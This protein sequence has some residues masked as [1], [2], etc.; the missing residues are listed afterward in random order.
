MIFL[1]LDNIAASILKGI[2]VYIK[3]V[4]SKLNFTAGKVDLYSD[5]DGTYCPARHSSL[6]DPAANKFMSEYCARMDSFFKSTNGD[7]HFN[8]TTGRTFGEY[9]AVSWLL[10]IRNFRLP[11]PETVITKDG[12]DRLLKNGSDMEFYEGGKFP[13]SYNTTSKEKEN[14]IKKMSNWDGEAI[15]KELR[16]LADKYKI[17]FVEADSQNSVSDYGN[18]SLYSSGKLDP[19][20][21]KK[22][23]GENGRILHHESPI[24][25]Y[26]L[27]SRN[28]GRLKFYLLFPPDYGFCPVRNGIYD[29]L[30]NDFKNYMM[31]NNISYNMVWEPAT[32]SNM[33]RISC[34]I[35]PKFENGALTKLYDTK[36]AVK[37]AAKN[38]DI[39]ITAGDG[40]NDFDMLNPIKYLDE[41]FLNQCEQKSKY[42]DFYHQDMKKCLEDLQKVYNN[43]ESIYIKGLRKELT[44]NGFL[45]TIEKMPIYSIVIKKKNTKLQPLIDAFEN[46]GKIVAVEKGKLDDGIKKIVKNHAEKISK[47]KNSMSE[48]FKSFI[49]GAKK[50]VKNNYLSL[51]IAALIFFVS[52][53]GYAG[54]KYFMKWHKNEDSTG[55]SKF[56]LNR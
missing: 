19:D 49:F 51:K 48:E 52:I 44:E 4:S 32:N 27:G 18:R 54:Y 14:N 56:N 5:F 53:T 55:S 2:S 41:D 45:R 47:Y 40:S 1:F 8:I 28:D 20:E 25:D 11:F 30:I 39:V 42:K 29:N 21:W 13:F 15:Y 37:K 38:N 46:T 31:S 43:D 24:A 36:D 6:H 3:S 12:S 34:S 10:K 7:I 33:H 26:V 16:R 22:L 9:E 17:R 50:S 35:T 23:P